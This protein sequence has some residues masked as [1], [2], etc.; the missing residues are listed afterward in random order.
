M[1]VQSIIYFYMYAILGWICEC[2]YCSVPAKKWINRGM[3]IGPY[4]PIYGF[5]ALLILFLLEPYYNDPIVLFVFAVVVTSVLE[6]IT[7]WVLEK[8][9]HTKWWDYSKRSFNLNGRVCLL[10]STLFGGLGLALVYLIHP[11]FKEIV[12]SIQPNTLLVIVI[13]ASLGFA[14]DVY[15]TLSTLIKTSTAMANLENS[16]NEFKE[17]LQE[18]KENFS[19]EQFVERVQGSRYAKEDDTSKGMIM[20]IREKATKNSKIK[21]ATNEHLNKA[22]PNKKS[23]RTNGRILESI[24][25]SVENFKTIVEEKEQEFLN[26]NED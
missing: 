9:F 2:I 23:S 7:S 12:T 1:I 15:N 17:H 3:L 25:N 19:V 11:W 26:K 10:N 20:Q 13:V 4:C 5:G 21:K 22:Y 6:Y 18:K 14:Y 24:M 8:L 16:V